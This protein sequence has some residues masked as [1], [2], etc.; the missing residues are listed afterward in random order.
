[1]K[2]NMERKAKKTA[3]L[4]KHQMYGGGALYM[5]SMTFFNRTNFGMKVFN[6]NKQN[7]TKPNLT[8]SKQT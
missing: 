6:Q 7:L 8:I 1:M 3:L 5:N 4:S 2:A